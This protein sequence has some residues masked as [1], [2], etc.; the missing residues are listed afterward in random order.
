MAKAGIR[1]EIPGFGP[2]MIQQVVSDYT[3]TLSAGGKLSAGVRERL[4]RLAELVDIHI[5]TSDTFGT[6]RSE[7]AEIPLEIRILERDRH[8][9]QKQRFV[10]EQCQ[11]RHVAAFGNGSNDGL[12]LKAVRAAGGLAVAV[13]NGEGCAVETMISANLFIHGAANALDLLLEPN[14]AKAGLRF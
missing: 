14:R 5:L 6:V 12:M 1:I 8:D 3:G 13:D 9:V 7:L 10:T 11:A 2:L 4:T